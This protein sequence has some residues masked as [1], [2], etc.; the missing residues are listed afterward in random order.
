MKQFLVILFVI[1][2]LIA[3]A[4]FAYEPYIKPLLEGDGDKSAA[5]ITVREERVLEISG[6]SRSTPS[7]SGDK[8]PDAAMTAT[9]APA[10]KAAQKK[11][12][13]AR[14]KSK[15]DQF[16]EERYPMPDIPTLEEIVGNWRAVPQRAY[17]DS[18]VSSESIAYD[19]VVDGQKIGSSTVAPG[20]PLK[21]LRLEGEVLVVSGPV[22]PVR[23]SVDKTD[24]KQRIQKRY[25]DFVDATEK[26]VSEQRTRAKRVLEEN[27][28]RLAALL[29]PPKQDR[30][31]VA[32]GDPRFGPVK[33]SLANGGVD[34]ARL[35]EA[36]SFHWNGTETVGGVHGGT[37]ETVTVKFA[38]E[39][40]FG[41]FPVDYKCLLRGGRVVA[42]IDPITEEEV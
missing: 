25:D 6:Y 20:T 15:I 2:G 28:D 35:E 10:P 22:Q 4:Y 18:V 17:P 33:Q 11:A 13:P 38:I 16:L 19:L 1:C 40:I 31:A 27:P 24:F 34:S 9:S 8:K 21:P 12:A 39:T 14:P 23:V 5:K 26:R 42:W 30:P 41:V 3:G 36:Q 29:D 32:T 7:G 37:Y